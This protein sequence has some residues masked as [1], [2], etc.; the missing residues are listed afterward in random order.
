MMWW[1]MKKIGRWSVS[2]FI[3]SVDENLVELV[4]LTVRYSKIFGVGSVKPSK[5]IDMVF[6][7]EN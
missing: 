5:V 6:I 2:V 3:N 1:K 4:G 7:L